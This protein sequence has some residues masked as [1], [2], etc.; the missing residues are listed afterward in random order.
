MLEL[1]GL[2][3][4]IPIRPKVRG[5]GMDVYS[6]QIHERLWF[7]YLAISPSYELARRYRSGPLTAQDEVKLP[8]D[9]E[10][11]LSVYDNLG[12]VQSLA[13][14]EWWRRSGSQ[15]LEAENEASAVAHLG[16][17]V[18]EP[19]SDGDIDAAIAKFRNE[20]WTKQGMPDTLIVAIPKDLDASLILHQLK[21]LI[22]WKRPKQRKQ[23]VNQP[24][25]KLVGKRIHWRV[26]MQYLYVLYLRANLPE[27]TDWKIGAHTGISSMHSAYI[28]PVLDEPTEDNF[29]RRH[30]LG[31]LTN[32]ALNKALMI[33]ENAAR[34]VFPSHQK[35]S[36]AV[37]FNF[38]V[39][40]E[41]MLIRDNRRIDNECRRYR[42]SREEYTGAELR[43]LMKLLPHPEKSPPVNA[44]AN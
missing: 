30:T 33:S 29:D 41:Q 37:K 26:L 2:L 16:T 35:V 36:D 43:K 20:R 32:R 31:I 17:L 19:A 1:G 18:R 24:A 34:G 3:N 25:Y 10:R 21:G 11:V 22:D 8:A 40:R 42:V 12:D 6:G 28:D 38:P 15:H 9:F 5:F 14:H 44:S 4:L 39:L 13:F 7:E 27:A 23:V